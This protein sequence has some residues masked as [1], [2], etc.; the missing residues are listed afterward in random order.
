M[1]SVRATRMTNEL[2]NQFINDWQLVE[3]CGAGKSALVF[4]AVRGDTTAA[5]KLFDPELV[6]KFGK[7][8]QKA[9]IERERELIGKGHPHLIN[10]IDGGEDIDKQLLYVAMEYIDAPNLADVIED[11]PRERIR[12]II[13]QIASAAKFLEELNLVHRDIKPDNIVIDEKFET[14]ILLDLGVI[15]PCGVSGLTDGS[16]KFFVGTLQYSSPEFLFRTEEDSTEGW[17]AV[18]FY[19]LGAVLHDLIM[20]KRIFTEF[21]DPW[22]RLVEAVKYEVPKIE[23]PDVSPELILLSQNCLQKDVNLRKRLVTWDDFQQ[24]DKNLSSVAGS[25]ERIR[26]RLLVAAEAPSFDDAEAEQKERLTRR[27]ANE[28]QAKLQEIVRQECL[29]SGLFPPL[30]IHEFVSES[31]NTTGFAIRFSASKKFGLHHDLCVNFRVQI[32]DYQSKA[33]EIGSSAHLCNSGASSTLE[34]LNTIFEGG[35]LE[36]VVKERLQQVLYSSLDCAQLLQ[37][38]DNAPDGVVVLALEEG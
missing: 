1:D 11:I 24:H 32:L 18:T 22:A 23:A 7:E 26:K 2:L 37:I 14:A 4:K 20:R 16:G 19:Q 28:I 38:P 21:Q 31:P 30:V 3:Y 29:E 13:A 12:P 5:I 10:I 17:R 35:Y 6:E 9:R 33:I 15:R 27:V 34:N 8:T 36:A 25:K